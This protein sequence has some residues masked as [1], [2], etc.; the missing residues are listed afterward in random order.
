MQNVNDAL[1]FF[2]TF[3]RFHAIPIDFSSRFVILLFCCIFKEFILEQQFLQGKILPALIRFSVPL[4][5]SLFLQALYGAVDLVVVGQFG[6]TASISAVATG[7]QLM[8]AVTTIVTG[9]TMGVTV[10]V[11]QAIGAGD[12][13]RAGNVVCGMIKLFCAVAIVITV[14]LLLFPRQLAILLHA[15][16]AA[17]EQTVLYICICGGGMVFITAYNAI[18]GIFRGIGNSATPFLFVAIACV[19]NILLDLLFVALLHMDAAGAAIATVIAQASS[20]FCSALY[21]KKKKLPFP[22]RRSGFSQKG[23]VKSIAAVG[24][25]IALQDFLVSVSFLIITAIVNNIGLTESASIGIAEKLF[26]FLSIVPMSFL[27]ALSAFVAQ[28]IGNGN[29]ERAAGALFQACG[30]SFAFGVAVF[31]LTFFGG[32]LLARIFTQEADV[33]AKTALYFK[34]CSFEYLIIA[35]SFCMLGYFNGLR[36]TIFVMV[37]GLVTAF[38]V[39]IPLSY[40]F[41]TLENTNMLMIGIAVPVSAAVSLILCL[42]FFFF[43]KRSLSKGQHDQEMPQEVSE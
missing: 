24:A 30:V 2:H 20:V 27:S 42:C 12:K 17:L 21:L 39:R 4:M 3:I 1:N 36:K 33:I 40:L 37:Q 22:V 15:P 5:L 11:G 26:V 19:V 34:S 25:P 29:S 10:L 31:F 43:V 32:H 13:E 8:V 7:S 6:S 35:L 9:L 18:S 28:N 38:G 41:S 23:T 16:Q 14:L